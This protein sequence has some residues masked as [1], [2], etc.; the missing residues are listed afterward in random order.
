MQVVVD[1]LSQDTQAMEGMFLDAFHQNELGDELDFVDTFFKSLKYASTTP[2]FG[3]V[4]EFERSTQL[5]T[6]MLLYNLKA[7]YGMLDACFAELLR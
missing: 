2:L 1:D 6:T 4:H 5:R 7:M 3:L